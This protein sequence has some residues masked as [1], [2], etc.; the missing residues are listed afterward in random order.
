MDKKQAFR[1]A[2]QAG[3]AM[4]F[5]ISKGGVSV[6]ER[7]SKQRK[8]HVQRLISRG[9]IKPEKRIKKPGYVWGTL[10]SNEAGKVEPVRGQKH[11]VIKQFQKSEAYKQKLASRKWQAGRVAQG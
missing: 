7:G 5:A 3:L 4:D 10:G 8:R 6:S 11:S 2:R 9:I 1:I